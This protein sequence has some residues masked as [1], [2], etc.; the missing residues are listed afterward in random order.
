MPTL[1][2]ALRAQILAETWKDN[3]LKRQVELCCCMP[4][5]RCPGGV[6]RMVQGQQP[7]AAAACAQGLELQRE[8]EKSQ[9]DLHTWKTL[10][11]PGLLTIIN[12][13]LVQVCHPCMPRPV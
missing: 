5:C 7:C 10:V 11:R 2:L 6:P 9:Q 1:A 12:I 4:C 8:Y 3:G 13:L